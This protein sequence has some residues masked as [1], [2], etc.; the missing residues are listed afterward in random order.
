[1]H[2]GIVQCKQTAI[3]LAYPIIAH[4]LGATVCMFLNGF[5]CN[6]QELKIY[7]P[8]VST[9]IFMEKFLLEVGYFGHKPCYCD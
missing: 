7:M 8:G 5:G 6:F 4:L 2:C 3:K 1:M 9:P